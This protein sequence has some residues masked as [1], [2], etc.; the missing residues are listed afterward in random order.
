MTSVWTAAAVA[1]IAAAPYPAL[2]VITAAEV[3]P[4]TPGIDLWDLWPLQAA[5]GSIASIAGGELWFA[6]SAPVAGD[7]LARH[8]AARIRTLRHAAGGW[9]DLG[10]TLPDGFSPG[11]REWSGSAV[12]TDGQVTLYFTA[13]GRRG[14]VAMTYEQRLFAATATLTGGALTNWRDCRETVMADGAMYVRAAEAQ[15]AV[16]TIKAFRDPGWC[17]DPADAAE[18][19]LFAGS[20]ATSASAWNGVI[21]AAQRSGDDWALLPPL[22]TAAGVNN[23]LE[24]PHLLVREGRYHLFWSTQRSVFARPGP[25]G[26]TG[27]YGMVA[28][29]FAGPYRPLN[30]TGLVLA[31]PPEAGGQAYSWL[32]LP[33]LRVVSFVDRWGI[34]DDIALD[35]ATARRHFGGVP[36]MFHQLTIDGDRAW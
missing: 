13:A 14:E 24:R 5:D 19:L 2:P 25:S 12:L 16:G 29:S 10:P 23:E 30:G 26:P 4:V 31:N 7:P 1:Q 22:V 11:S 27:L 17:R 8:A 9:Q 34:A 6:L 21:G 20:D 35:A 33:D 28:D 32:V 36:A 18:Y 3:V 15:G